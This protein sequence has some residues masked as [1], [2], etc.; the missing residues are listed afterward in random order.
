MP[1]GASILKLETLNKFIQK[2]PKQENLLFVNLFPTDQYPS[3]TIR[4]GVEYGSVGMT[5]FVAPGSPAPNVGDDQYYSEGSAVAAYWKEKTF[6]DEVALNNL[7]EPLTEQTY[8]TAEKQ[9]ARKIARLRA[10]CDRRKEWMIS[11]MLFNHGFSYQIKGGAKFSVDYNVPSQNE[12]ALS[13]NDFWK[14]A[15]GSKGSSA[16]P[17]KDVFDFRQDYVDDL[18]REPEY[19]VI[20]S[21]MLKWWMFDDDLQGIL[22]KSAFGEGD[23]FS[24]PQGVFAKLFGL[25]NLIVYDEHFDVTSWLTSD[26]SSTSVVVEDA[27]DFVAGKARMYD[28]S[29]MFTY[30]DVE[31][32]AV[33]YNT[34]TLTLADSPT[35][36]YSSGKARISLRKKFASEDKLMFFS[37]SVEGETIAE[38]MEAPFGLNRNWG[39]FGDSKPEWDPDGVWLRIQ[40]KGLPVMYWPNAVMTLKVFEE[41]SGS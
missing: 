25:G 27:T 8:Y 2:L 40:N 37:K 26:C 22:K 41:E 17:I 10:R 13:G 23:L 19:T 9:I 34:N 32:T 24:N 21:E 29:S 20:T 39:M 18:G 1:K 16:T 36:T 3:D 12:Q 11:Q 31:I 35:S 15:D 4:W 6:I 38:F 28:M 5:P 33:N 14:T 7:R 30:E